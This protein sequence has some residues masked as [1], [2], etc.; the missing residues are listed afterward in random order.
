MQVPCLSPVAL[1]AGEEPGV[2][3]PPRDIPWPHSQPNSLEKSWLSAHRSIC[4]SVSH[5]CG[6]ARTPG[7]MP[8]SGITASPKRRWASGLPTTLPAWEPR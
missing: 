3:Q 7:A 2:T 6:W 1:E 8:S 5:S 4:L